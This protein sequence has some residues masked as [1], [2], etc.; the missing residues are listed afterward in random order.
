[1]PDPGVTYFILRC[2]YTPL[3]FTY[4]GCDS[5]ARLT[6]AMFAQGVPPVIWFSSVPCISTSAVKF[7]EYMAAVCNA[8]FPFLAGSA[9]T[10]SL[11]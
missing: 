10:T 1:M 6:V 5:F 8:S 7:V 9:V 4:F 11:T 3:K 2:V